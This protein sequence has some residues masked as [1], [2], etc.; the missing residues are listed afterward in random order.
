M[1]RIELRADLSKI[2]RSDIEPNILT[3]R[4]QSA[5]RVLRDFRPVRS[6]WYDCAPATLLEISITP[7]KCVVCGVGWGSHLR[8]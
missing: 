1:E 7:K 5:E 8:Y 3:I 4:T 2:E 6:L